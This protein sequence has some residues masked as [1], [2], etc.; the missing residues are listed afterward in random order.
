MAALIPGSFSVTFPQRDIL[1]QGIKYINTLGDISLGL[2]GV[3]WKQVIRDIKAAGKRWRH[4]GW[5][6]RVIHF[7]FFFNTPVYFVKTHL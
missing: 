1:P 5:Q 2:R 3:S 6:G 4:R 7:F